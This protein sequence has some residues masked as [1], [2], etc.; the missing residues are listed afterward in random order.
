MID[1]NFYVLNHVVKLPVLYF[2]ATNSTY[3]NQRINADSNTVISFVLG[4]ILEVITNALTIIF[5][6]YV[7]IKINVKLTLVLIPL[8][9][10]YVFLYFAF[11][12]PLYK[13][14]YDL[15]EKQNKFFQK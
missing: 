1:L 2:K 9:P 15:K 5:L 3:L 6:T 8:I 13:Q 7:S 10:V 14:G 4:N 12:K 11:R